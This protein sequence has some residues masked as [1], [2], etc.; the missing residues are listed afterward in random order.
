MARV[1][2]VVLV[3]LFSLA[4]AHRIVM[5][6]PIIGEDG[7]PVEYEFLPYAEPRLIAK[8]IVATYGHRFVS[9]GN[10]FDGCDHGDSEVRPVF[11]R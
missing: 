5:I 6:L 10:K 8:H 3:A 2:S 1:L 11:L 7:R 4:T 9:P